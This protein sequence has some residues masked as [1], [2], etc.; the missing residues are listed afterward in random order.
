MNELT[1]RFI[2]SFILLPLLILVILEG[3][4]FFKLFILICLVI[5]FYEWDNLIKKKGFVKNIGFLF[6]IFSFYSIYE[7]R[8]KFENNYLYLLIIFLI[9]V[10]TD[11]GGYIFGRVFK[12]PKL[13]KISPNKTYSG[14]I[15]SYILTLLS[16]I[17]FNNLFLEETFN[18][19]NNAI[20]NLLIFGAVV[21]FISQLGDLVI[22]YFKR[23]YKIKDTG[24]IIPG[25]GG[26]LDRID[27]MI[28]AFPFSYIILTNKIIEIF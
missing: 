13:T 27:G 16:L 4:F 5:T 3:S 2:S 7:L 11:T 12:G 21:S 28:F 15:G 9:C 22:S 18:L 19:K 20:Y 25:H 10:T 26:L 6:L 17:I 8:T 24:K 23:I 1:K 14:M